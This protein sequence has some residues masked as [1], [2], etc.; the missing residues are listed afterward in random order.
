MVET[1]W[2][3]LRNRE[4]RYRDHT[5][6]LTGDVDVSGNGDQLGVEAVQTDDVRRQTARLYFGLDGGS[7]SLNPGDLGT[8]FDRLEHSPQTQ[9]LVVKKSGRAYRYELQRMEYE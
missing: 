3:D 5:W 6:K 2:D 4:L 1:H 8:H 9:S 7:G